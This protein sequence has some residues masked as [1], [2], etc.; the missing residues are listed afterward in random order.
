MAKVFLK[1]CKMQ[2]NIK[3]GKSTVFGYFVKDPERYG[4]A[5]FDSNGVAISI[6][7]KPAK[8]KSNYAIVGLYFYTND[9]VEIA[10]NSTPSPRGE[11]EITDINQ[12]YLNSNNL[13]VELLGEVLLG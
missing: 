4:V 6:E 11:L 9:V 3:K 2:K 5:E 8:P 10:K 7:E 1:P 13:R 12:A